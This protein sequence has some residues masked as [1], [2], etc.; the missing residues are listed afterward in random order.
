MRKL[1]LILIT[2]SISLLI[3]SI[4][5]FFSDTNKNH[6]KNIENRIFEKSTVLLEI[7]LNKKYSDIQI[8]N[9]TIYLLESEDNK[10]VSFSPE[11][12]I[13]K[14]EYKFNKN[15]IL[16]PYYI[17]KNKLF[18][19]DYSS[20]R[21]IISNN[22]NLIYSKEFEFPISRLSM[23]T[24]NYALIT[25]WDEEY[26]PLFYK[27][28]IK[29]D[30]I[31]EIIIDPKVYDKLRYPGLELDG[32]IISN[33]LFTYIIPYG[34]NVVL[35]FNNNLDFIKSFNLNFQ[36]ND[37]KLNKGNSEV[38]I[39]PNNIFPNFS[40]TADNNYIYILTNKS[41]INRNIE[42]YFI[43]IYNTQTNK[44]EKSIKIISN[45]DDLPREIT[46]DSNNIYILK[47]R[48]LAI[49]EKN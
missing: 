10:I 2:I 23:V 16:G 31:K 15:I 48:S 27:F 18:S 22:N 3:V 4:I 42:N 12:N 26:N 44:Y 5:Y 34:Q 47:D 19:K 8:F 17:D 38:F 46:V 41:G 25:T 37:F 24:D 39:D 40:A 21:L 33:D 9:N 1:I 20:N 36:L 30:L 35:V 32:I 43:D 45:E 29:N 13:F 14:E 7:P 49:Y 6:V 11:K 28:N